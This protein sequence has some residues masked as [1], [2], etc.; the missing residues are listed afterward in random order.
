MNI[1]CDYNA[2]DVAVWHVQAV[3]DADDLLASR[4]VCGL[5]LDPAKDVVGHGGREYRVTAL[6][7][8]VELT[9]AEKFT[10]FH[11]SN[12]AVYQVMVG[13]AREWVSRTGR[14]K[15][16]INSL[17]ERVRW[18]IAMK[19][20]DPDFKINNNLA[21]FYSRMIMRQEPDLADLFELRKSIAD[22]WAAA[23]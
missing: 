5:H 22:E 23:A 13:L 3:G 20:N 10:R 8:D 6:D 14:Q 19:T 11:E 9:P 18:E 2:A 12:P 15:L 7:G 16:G 21:P 17:V 1:T 4:F